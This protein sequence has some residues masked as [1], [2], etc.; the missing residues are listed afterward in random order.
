MHG[1]RAQLIVDGKTVGIFSD[2]SWGL[3]YD[4]QPVYILGRFSAA[5][6][7]Y[8]AQETVQVS[9]RGFRIVDHGPHEDAKVP[10][11]QELLNHQ[12]ITLAIYDRQSGKKLATI[13]GCRPIGYETSVSS[14]ALQEMTVTFMGLLLDDESDAT[15][16]PAAENADSTNLP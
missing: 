8:T 3:R 7:G 1:A 6:I 12:D 13:T 14:R 4:A 10:K 9:A 15:K 5:E 2:C 16:G 11:L